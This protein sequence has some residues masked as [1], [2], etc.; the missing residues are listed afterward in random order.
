MECTPFHSYVQ[1]ES[2]VRGY[3]ARAEALNLISEWRRQLAMPT[4]GLGVFVALLAASAAVTAAEQ[5]LILIGVVDQAGEPLVGLQAHDFSVENGGVR[6]EIVGLTPASYPLAVVLDTSSYAR[7]DFRTLQSAAEQFLEAVSSRPIAVYAS[8]GAGARLQDF[9]S[10]RTRIAHAVAS[11][12]AAPNAST[13]TLETIRRA[14]TDLAR[15]KVPVTGIIVVSAGGIEM[16]PPASQHVWAALIASGSM[17]NV[18][19]YRT[20]HL[21]R[22]ELQQD[23]GEVLEALAVRSHGKYFRGASAAV[24]ASGFERVREQLDAQSILRYAVAPGVPHSLSV[25]V[26]PPAMVVM[27]VDLDR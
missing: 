14:S 21:G 3:N 22:G 9:T 19:E 27:A 4:A 7:T 18:I 24:Y 5:R 6:C 13:S 11:A 26:K 12:A 25:L 15:L 17:L 2:H 23:Q 1:W 16:S 10:D 8:G 20:L